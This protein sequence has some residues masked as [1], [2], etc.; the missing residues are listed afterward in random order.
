[1]NFQSTS[2]WLSI[3]LCFAMVLGLM[4]A[5]A[6]ATAGE[7]VT[8][9]VAQTTTASADYYGRS[10]LSA[11]PNAT[12]LVYAY[13][14]LA[15][16]VEACAESITVYNGTD[17][18]TF[19]E[20]KVA[21]DAY[22][23][24][25]AHHFW[26]GSNYRYGSNSE[27]V[28]Y[29]L[30]TYTMTGTE[31]EAAKAS[32]EHRVTDILSGITGSMTEYEKALY[33][34]DKLADLITYEATAQAHNVYGAL[35]EG[36]A[37]CEGY[38]EALQYLLQRVGMQSFL[39]IGASINPATNTAENHEWNYVR[40]DGN[41]YHVDLTWDDQDDDL[42]HDYFNQTDAV[43]QEDHVIGTAG[44][45]LP[46]CNSTTAQFFTGKEEYLSTYDADTI[47]HLLQSHHMALHVYIPGSIS[48]FLAWYQE[49]IHAISA[50]AGVTGSFSYGYS[51]L[52]RELIL[53]LRISCSHTDLTL[54]PAV[55]AAETIP[56][57]IPYYQCACG[58]YFT[59]AAASQEITG[60]SAWKAGDGKLI[61]GQEITGSAGGLTWRLTNNKLT[62]SG[63]MDDYSAEAAP[64][65]GYA[66]MIHTVHA[67]AGITAI[68]SNA[69]YGCSNLTTFIA[70]ASLQSVAE[71]AFSGCD[72]LQTVY[73]G[74]AQQLPGIPASATLYCQTVPAEDDLNTIL[75][76]VE[77]GTTVI[78]T[79]AVTQSN[80]VVG[81]NITLDL[82]GYS[83][84]T[85][86]F[87]CYGNV[88]DGTA[89]G[90]G[91]ITATMGIYIAGKDSFL[92]IYDSAAGGYRFYQYSLQHLGYK[93]VANDSNAV[94]A[95]IRLTL[96]NTAGY[97]LLAAAS[98][99]SV[100]LSVQIGLSNWSGDMQYQFKENTLHNYASQVCKDIAEKG[101]S[102]CAILLTIR[103]LDN[104]G[105][106]A[107]LAIQPKVTTAPG[108]TA[109]GNA[110][111][112]SA[113]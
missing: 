2:R 48:D 51:R 110:V 12:A 32:F 38:S 64:W 41:Y 16:G 39:A 70:P 40:I 9:P 100:S 14:Q 50:N 67:E 107:T 13:D 66:H 97:E 91:L 22:T 29:I 111:T 105:E 59:D 21:L 19:A 88:T 76:S 31:L 52:G 108:F 69:F 47:G 54:Q 80:T 57:H 37:V 79:Q 6:L 33:L 89:G 68:G 73:Y 85:D 45:A 34:H 35:V 10:A 75:R 15:A 71:T 84:T 18:I 58:R 90:E 26:L 5:T 102:S 3:L 78:M 42:Y 99:H 56:G 103:G 113:A 46:V 74:G 87:T 49:N 11:L 20:F 106:N 7:E 61:Y 60:L 101:S 93:A 96:K 55:A 17:P 43:I 30:P 63:T 53:R 94:L 25:Y 92:P 44:Y 65:Q 82:N 81:N 24:D 86:F 95:G 62:L 8:T 1:M 27:T 83:L 112:W 72:S 4:P 104:M 23:R 98:N 77:A 28:V 36:K 109:Q